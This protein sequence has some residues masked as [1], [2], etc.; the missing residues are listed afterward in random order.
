LEQE[1]TQG[2]TLG[3]LLVRLEIGDHEAWCDIFNSK[4]GQIQPAIMTILNSTIMSRSVA[5]QTPLSDG[6]QITLRI[7]Y[8]GG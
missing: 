1:T 7:V 3:D 8:S 6:D 2:E 5:T 4:T